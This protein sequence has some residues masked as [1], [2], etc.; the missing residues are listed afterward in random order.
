MTVL[1]PRQVGSESR[2]TSRLV[3]PLGVVAAMIVTILARLAL[4]G[5]NLGSDEAGY[6]TVAGQWHAGGTSLYGNLWVD[7]P[8]LLITIFR[9]AAV[10]GGAVPLRVIGAVAA[11]VTVGVVGWTANRLGG[12]R[13]ATCAAIVAGG[14]LSNCHAGAL[15]VD[16]ELLAAPFIAVGIAALVSGSLSATG[17]SMLLAGLVAGTSAAAAVLVKQN[18]VDVAVFAGALVVMGG[19]ALG[20]RRIAMCAAGFAAGAIAVILVMAR[21]TVAH[22]TSLSGVWFAMYR[23]RLEADRV[24]AASSPAPIVAR[25]HS[26]MLLVLL[27]GMAFSAALLA[28]AVIRARHDNP[29]DGRDSRVR[30]CVPYALAV[31]LI[32]EAASVAMGQNYFSHYLVQ[33]VVPL[34]LGVGI[35]AGH[36]RRPAAAVAGLVAASAVVSTI[37]GGLAPT[38]GGLSRVGGAIGQVSRPGDTVVS[39][40]GNTEL[41]RA[42][43]LRSPYPYLWA[44]PAETLDPDNTLL[45]STLRGV[46]APTWFV[47]SDPGAPHTTELD[48]VLARRY[49]RVAMMQG[50]TIYLRD[51]VRRTPPALTTASQ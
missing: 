22:G 9:L 35:V 16:G 24:M 25:E 29:S 43:G 21:W 7:R 11:A 4:A 30:R 23:F 17:R 3:V 14:L 32:Y 48:R 13:A 45:A 47:T 10:L 33:L 46:R 12:R 20:I 44:L 37:V 39:V 41:M 42:T 31:T 1:V 8:P 6:L 19:R 34:A 15:S 36:H 40:W 5:E 49:H 51:G 26:M 2:Q 38:D 18:M 50:R 28:L 27:N